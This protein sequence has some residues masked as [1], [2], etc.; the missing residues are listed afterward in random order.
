MHDPETFDQ[1]LADATE[2]LGRAS[3]P[4]QHA[5]LQTEFLG[6]NGRLTK[7][8]KD[9]KTLPESERR[10]A[11]IAGNTA[12]AKLEQLFAVARREASEQ[13]AAPVDV[14][15]PGEQFQVGHRHPV[16]AVLRELEDIFHGLGFTTVEGPEVEDD[17]HNFEALNMGP[18]HPARDMQDTFYLAGSEDAPGRFRLLPRTHT[19][20]VQIRAMRDAKPPIRIIAPGLVYRNEAED[21]THSAVFHQMEGLLVDDRT[22][23]ADLKGVLTEAARELL[24]VDTKIRFRP[25]FFPYTEPSAEIDMS[26]PHVRNGEWLELGGCGM[27]HPQVLRNV[28]W[29]PDQYLGFAFGLGPARI[30]MLKYG[31]DD[32][33]EFFAPDIR[34]MEQF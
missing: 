17:W 13:P 24:G 18:D 19:S 1:I 4:A 7:A 10:T 30:A 23:F 31:I 11:G 22:T 25:S 26:V 16:L 33:R 5:K 12:K 27:V 9:I 32:I 28:K 6:R 15:L 2:A 34:L 3:G 14:T 29:D 21:A 20:G 8:L